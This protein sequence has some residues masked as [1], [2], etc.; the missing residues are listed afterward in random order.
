MWI[1]QKIKKLYYIV[2]RIIKGGV[3]AFGYASIGDYTVI[4]KPMRVIGKKYIHLGNN[5]YIMN[6]L[7]IEVW[8]SWGGVKKNF[9]P[10]VRIENNVSIQQNCH[11]TCA[12]KIVIGSGT[13]VLPEVLITD[14][15]HIKE[16]G[17][18][19]ND[20]GIRAGE[21]II[22]N[23]CVIGMGARILSNGKRITIGNDCV[24]GANAV[25]TSCIPDGSIA[26]GIPA[27]VIKKIPV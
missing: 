6:N 15:D 21:V 27:R 7:R 13:S 3:H 24:I 11:I 1:K 18:S 17:K 8:D 16:V 5:D 22:G 23:N 2:L 26:V 9:S 19:V 12:N 14:I 20:T 10:T 4:C 25:V